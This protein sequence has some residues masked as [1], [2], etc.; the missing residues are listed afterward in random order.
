MSL[1]DLMQLENR[2]EKSINKIRSKKNELLYAEMIEYMQKRILEMK[3]EDEAED[4]GAHTD[5]D[6]QWKGKCVVL[7]TSTRKIQE[8]VEG[9]KP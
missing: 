1:R 9:L 7:R 2:L 3:L 5:F 6:S 4:D 8:L